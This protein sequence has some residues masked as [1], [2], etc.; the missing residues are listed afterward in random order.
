VCS[1]LWL[2]AEQYD[3]GTS[4]QLGTFPQAFSHVMLINTAH[5]L[6]REE[7]PAEER[8]KLAAKERQDSSVLSTSGLSRVNC[9]FSE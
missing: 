3:P 8:R 4:R 2:L 1:D 5:N 7:G 9:Q 6:A